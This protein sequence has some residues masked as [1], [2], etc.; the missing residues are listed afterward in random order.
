ML[1][2]FEQGVNYV[3]TAAS[4][5]DGHAEELIG[6]SLREW[7][8]GKVYVATKLW[9]IAWPSP[10]DDSPMMRGRYPEWYLRDGVE[11]NLRGLCVERLDLFQLHCWLDSGL[12]ELD[13]LETLNALRKEGKIDRVG[14]SIRD[15]RPEEG[16][17]L[18]RY[19]LVDSQQVIFNLFDQRPMDALFREGERTRTA[20]VARVPYDS[21]SLIGNWTEATYDDW[22]S[23]DVRHHFFRGDRYRET[24][25][26]VERLKGVCSKYFPTLAE[27][28][29]RFSLSDPAVSV[30]IPGMRTTGEVDLNLRYSD[31]RAFPSE[32]REA[33][34]EHRWE[35]NF[36][37]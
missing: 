12:E 27:A 36:Y 17:R 21:S 13:W 11:G 20:F 16:I 25:Q 37:V 19:G 3:D 34:A 30:V 35:R 9:P 5:G 10:S 4:Y 1:H 2:A 7:K 31:G 14:V 28:A 23:D 18:A 26:R 8:G 29:L 24:I 22:T 33:L 15:N 6:Q 32:L